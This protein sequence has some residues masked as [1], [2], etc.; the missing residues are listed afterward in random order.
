MPTRE[1]I[2]LI[3]RAPFTFGYMVGNLALLRH[4]SMVHL[5]LLCVIVVTCAVAE[6]FVRGGPTLTL[7]LFF[8]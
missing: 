7:F 1:N 5:R 6:G 2:R 8:S 4:A 3:A